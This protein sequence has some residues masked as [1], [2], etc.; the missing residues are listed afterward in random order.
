MERRWPQRPSEPKKLTAGPISFHDPVPSR[1]GKTVFALGTKERGELVRYDSKAKQFVP[2]LGG[3]SATNVSF[4][5]DGK[6]VAYRSFPDRTLW[7]SRVDGTDRLQLA[8]SPVGENNTFSPDGKRLEYEADGNIYLIAVDGGQPQAIVSDGKSGWADWSPAGN[9]LVFFTDGEANM[10]NLASGKRSVVSGAHDLEEVR[11][12]AEDKL[13]ARSS[14]NIFT[15]FDMKNQ[16]W[17]NWAIEPKPEVVSRW[18]VSPEQHYLYYAAGG[19]EPALMRVRLGD[20]RAETITSLKDFPF[21]M[22]IQQHSADWLISVAPD[23]SPLLTRDIG[24]QEI[25]A[26]SVKWP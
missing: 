3:I 14:E 6:W 13:V 18:G 8:Y 26:L 21:A 7:R 11:W 22:F 25:Y 1:D 23:G 4:S 24:S 12:I 20:N 5:K 17:S 10:L 15:I 16:T 9:M 19:A 2:F